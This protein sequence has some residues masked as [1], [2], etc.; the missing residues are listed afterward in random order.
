MTTPK[1]KP[2]LK[3][4]PTQVSESDT[5]RKPKPYDFVALPSGGKRLGAVQGHHI[6][7]DELLNGRLYLSLTIQTTSFV[8]SGLTVL[9]SD[10]SSKIPLIKTSIFNEQKLIIPGSSLKG[11]I[12]SAYEAITKSCLCKTKAQTNKVPDNFSECRI[13]REEKQVCPACQLFGAMGW[14]GLISFPDVV[15]VEVSTGISFVPSLYAPQ[16]K[17]NNYYQ[18]NQQIKGRKFYYH[19]REAVSHGEKGIDA[20]VATKNYVFKAVLQLKNVSKQQLGAL[21]IVLGQDPKHPMALKVGGGKPIGMGTMTVEIEALEKPQRLKE[22]RYTQYA[23]P[24]S[25]RLTGNSLKAFVEEAIQ[26]AHRGLVEKPQLEALAEI[27]KW[28]TDRT[29][30]EGM[31]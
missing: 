31:Y 14:Q 22:E 7:E 6:L 24:E 15:G 23:I 9:G 25:N 18:S 17:S 29:A 3:K 2:V 20:Q 8:A 5:D 1:P 27:L 26:A 4:K 30:P 13:K 28:P 16:S 10:L 21:C 11:T 19:A 12:R